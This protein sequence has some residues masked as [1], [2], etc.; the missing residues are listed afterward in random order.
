MGQGAGNG[1]TW[2]SGVNF[3]LFEGVEVDG[4]G[5]AVFN[6]T[7]A[8]AHRHGLNGFQLQEAAPGTAFAIT[9]FDYSP[10]TDEITLTWTSIPGETYAVKFS[11]DMTN[12]ESDLDD[13]IPASAGETTTETFDLSDASLE[14][15]ERV[16]F[17][18]ER[19]D[20]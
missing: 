15:A 8:A 7:A 10:E 13:G 20:N 9:V 18:V 14:D 19:Q 5:T 4:S 6:S 11:G 17:R 12:W 16:Y 1:D 2:V 3:V